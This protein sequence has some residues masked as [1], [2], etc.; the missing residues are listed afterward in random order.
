MIN[1]E[2]K[3][4]V[5]KD[6][7]EVYIFRGKLAFPLNIAVHTWIVINNKGKIDR[8]DL[9]S[10]HRRPEKK[11]G[12]IHKNVLKPT[13]WFY[14]ELEDN[15]LIGKVEG[16]IAKETINFIEKNILNYPY[17]NR[18]SYFPGPNSNTF[19]QWIL[20]NNPKVKIK[21]P[22]RAIGKCYAKKIK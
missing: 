9:L 21:L 19:T 5:D 14:K 12:Y 16:L 4:V 10:P 18:Y 1:T 6:K 15:K 7:Y 22:F 3:S 20:N 13:S 8:W 2:F 11:Y 17:K